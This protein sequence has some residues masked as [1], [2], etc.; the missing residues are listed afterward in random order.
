MAYEHI[1]VQ[2]NHSFQSFAWRWPK[3]ERIWYTTSPWLLEK[4]A[5]MD[6]M[7]RSLED[8]ILQ[9]EIDRLGLFCLDLARNLETFIDRYIITNGGETS[10]GKLFLGYIRR[11]LYPLLYKAYVFIL[12]SRY[13]EGRGE[14]GYVIGLRWTLEPRIGRVG[15]FENVYTD[16]AAFFGL[17]NI[18]VI[19]HVDECGEVENLRVMERLGQ[20]WAER[21]LLVLNA[22]FPLLLLKFCKC[23][24]GTKDSRLIFNLRKGA[25]IGVVEGC[26]LLEETVAHL[27]MKGHAIIFVDPPSP[28]RL[29]AGGGAEAELND[30]EIHDIF[31]RVADSTEYGSER[32]DYHD[33]SPAVRYFQPLLKRTV[34]R[35]LALIKMLED[36]DFLESLKERARGMPLAIASAAFG[37]P[38]RKIVS[39]FLRKRGIPVYAFEHGITYGL[40]EMTKTWKEHDALCE[41]DTAMCYSGYAEQYHRGSC[42][43]TVFCTGMP[44]L[45]KNLRFSGLQRFMTRRLLGIPN[46]NRLVVY[47]ANLY[48]HN[49]IHSPGCPSDTAYHGFKKEVVFD[50]LGK[51]ADHV[52]LKLYPTLRYLDGD[53]FLDLLE[54]PANVSVNQFFEYRFLRATGDVV[55]C[56]SPQSTLGWAWSSRVPLVF[57]DL[58]SNAL[59][60]E[61]ADA[62]DQAIF[63]I[64]C[65]LDGWKEELRDLLLLPHDE[66][67]RIWRYKEEARRNVGER[68]VF[69]PPG[70]A[71]AR[72]A[73]FMINEIPNW[74][75]T[76][77]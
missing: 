41:S 77:L 6:E 52:L 64:D 54:M 43:R 51:I 11:M 61:V 67:L 63:R 36:G 4:L 23:L 25:C 32:L 24:L 39:R 28:H 31:H 38:E 57:L 5:V 59:I 22:S 40:C 29:D 74:P 53:P 16:L 68:F 70:N 62:F 18:E 15:R 3:E 50:V 8:G 49:Y 69:G 56:D 35:C 48:Y 73:N 42:S 33:L 71:G 44:D 12:W 58:P 10:Y 60:S 66:L 14:N 27:A 20:S 13:L 37:S 21:S 7:A 30:Q 9:S 76:D 19:E 75:R 47:V 2:D 34:R 65:G 72:A 45:N 26:E 55:L 17:A 1:I 46:R